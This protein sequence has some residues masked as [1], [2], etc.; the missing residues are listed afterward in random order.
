MIRWKGVITIA[1]ITGLF[2]TLSFFLTDRWVEKKLE[3]LGSAVVGAK[4]E[5]DNL[6]ISF[7]QMLISWSRLQVTHPQ[8]TM[9]NMFETG[10]SEFD[11]EFWPLLSKKVIIEDF[12]IT[13]FRTFTD[14][15]T[16]G[17]LPKEESDEEESFIGKKAKSI[18]NEVTKDISANLN[19]LRSNVNTDSILKILDIQSVEKIDSLKTLLNDKY[20]SWDK[21]LKEMNIEE[22]AKNVEQRIK[23]I[24][25]NNI[26]SVS[27]LQTTITNINEIKKT[28]EKSY[29]EVNSAKKDIT[30]DV[31]FAKE[32]LLLVDDWI[33]DD[34][35]RAYGMAKI[36]DLSVKNIAKLL[37]GETLMSKLNQYLYYFGK[38]RE[39]S[40]K[41]KSDKPEKIDPPRFK[42]QDIYFYSKNARPDFWIKRTDL[43]GATNEGL[44][45]AGTI[46]N[47]V[48]DQRFINKPTSFD[49]KGG[50]PQGGIKASL[51]GMLNYLEEQPHETLNL[52]YAGFSLANTQLSTSKLFPSKLSK[53][54]GNVEANIDLPGDRIEG[55]IKFTANNISFDFSGNEAKNKI[56]QLI[57]DAI[58]DIKTFYFSAKIS[59]KRSNIKVSIQSNLDKI[60]VDNLKK[61]V[62]KEIEKTKKQIS[63][64]I[65]KEVNAKKAELEKLVKQYEDK[66]N[67]ELAKYQAMLDKETAKADK[68][69]KEVEDR[70]NKEKSKLQDKVKD[71][72]KGLF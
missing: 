10:K 27:Q 16:D 24:D 46:D 44:Q 2:I 12:R 58:K 60:I 38:A 29:N 57:R 70:I 47:I 1:V 68:K 26:K 20:V 65:D 33:A 18:S 8:H 69:K 48:S 64:R 59:G 28:I 49:F 5:I 43:S 55:L 4:V 6:N 7:S 22:D 39:Y 63:D 66:L 54:T 9:K 51:N 53:G 17:A 61:S 71:K 21:R 31:K 30:E 52:K 3:D 42:G 50:N 62:N 23:K 32:K 11:L 15:E 72:L 40:S 35:R 67:N 19:S 37:F 36:P 56:T 13:D 25:V 45:L 34:Y 14:R 41:L